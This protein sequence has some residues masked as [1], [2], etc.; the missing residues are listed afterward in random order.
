[1][2]TTLVT[3]TLLA[4][5]GGA[6]ERAERMAEEAVAATAA[7]PATALARSLEALALTSSF[8]PTEF[9]DAGRK[10]ELVEDAFVAALE[11]LGELTARHGDAEILE[12]EFPGELDRDLSLCLER[13][14]LEDLTRAPA[15]LDLESAL[16]AIDDPLA[17]VIDDHLRATHDRRCSRMRD[18]QARET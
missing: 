16:L 7:D 17:V 5:A 11:S 2:Q 8:V 4:A 6:M 1:M 9:V 18:Q 14:R 13:A 12:T 15:G 10:G 3:L